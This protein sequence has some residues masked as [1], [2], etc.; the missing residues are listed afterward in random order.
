MNPIDL[1]LA[2]LTEGTGISTDAWAADASLDAT[3][4]HWRFE[5][6]GAEAIA[7]ELSGWYDAAITIEGAVRRPIPGGE[8]VELDLAWVEDG[9]PHA[10]HQVHLF[11]VDA[12]RISRDT[13]FC[14]GRWSAALLAEMEAAR[15]Q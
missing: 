12:G 8:A 2:E 1:F 13:V 4:P 6:T 7:A 3:V 14:G 5:C 15:A 9:V 10:A 11:T